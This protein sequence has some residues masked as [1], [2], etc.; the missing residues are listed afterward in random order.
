MPETYM[1]ILLVRRA[2]QLRKETADNHYY[3][4]MEASKKNICETVESVLTRP[5]KMLSSEPMLLAISLYMGESQFVYG[6]HH[7]N[8]GVSGL[9]FLPV[10]FGALIAVVVYALI[11]G[12]RYERE[13]EN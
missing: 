9:M 3:A 12:P 5:F 10:F 7:L 2:K 11:F 13:V 4:P 6:W 1:P 8:P